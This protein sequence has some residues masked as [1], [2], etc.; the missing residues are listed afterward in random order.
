[1]VKFLLEPS[2]QHEARRSIK[3]YLRRFAV[4]MTCHDHVE[5]ILANHGWVAVKKTMCCLLQKQST[6]KI[7]I[8]KGN[9]NIREKFME[10]RQVG[11]KA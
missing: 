7:R 11:I 3:E 5:S 2:D 10:Q 6:Q 1:M 8:L 9:K 4:T